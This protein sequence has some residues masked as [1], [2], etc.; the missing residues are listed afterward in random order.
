VGWRWTTKSGRGIQ[1]HSLAFGPSAT[2]RRGPANPPFGVWDRILRTLSSSSSS[3]DARRLHTLFSPLSHSPLSSPKAL[4]RRPD[5][6]PATIEP[7][8]DLT[9]PETIECKR[10]S[11]EKRKGYIFHSPRRGRGAEAFQSVFSHIDWKIRNR[12]TVTMGAE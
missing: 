11:V 8:N 10:T 1:L 3:S 9:N 2:F 5:E 6:Q 7:E 4:L 12:Y